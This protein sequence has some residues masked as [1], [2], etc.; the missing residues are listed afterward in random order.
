MACRIPEIMQATH[1][2]TT[3]ISTARKKVR[4]LESELK[5]ALDVL[6]RVCNRLSA[7]EHGREDP[8]DDLKVA[9]IV[10]S[11]YRSNTKS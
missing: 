6:E 1:E 7:Y 10:L 11:N 4:R 5:D 2:M 3:R 9:W 8:S